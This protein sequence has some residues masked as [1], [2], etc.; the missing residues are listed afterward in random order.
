[1]IFRGCTFE[2][3]ADSVASMVTVEAGGK[4]VFIGCVFR[5]SGVSTLPLVAHGGG[6]ASVQIAFC[7]NATPNPLLFVVGNATGTGN[8]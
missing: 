8:I 3:P 6:A 1:M 2:R 4:A 7:Y 5:G